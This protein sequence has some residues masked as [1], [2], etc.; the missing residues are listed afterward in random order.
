METK[1]S[2]CMLLTLVPV[3]YDDYQLHTLHT[4]AKTQLVFYILTSKT[5]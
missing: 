1:L 2:N 4:L 5:M 3:K